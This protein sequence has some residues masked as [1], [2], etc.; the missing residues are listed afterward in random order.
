MISQVSKPVSSLGNSDF[1]SDFL[2][3]R[4]MLIDSWK[5]LGLNCQRFNDIDA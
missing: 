1:N 5:F 4:L 2:I 3:S